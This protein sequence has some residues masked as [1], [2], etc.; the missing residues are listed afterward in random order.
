M[1]CSATLLRMTE[2]PPDIQARRTLEEHAIALGHER[3][4]LQAREAEIITQAIA[5]M[6]QE[7]IPAN[8]LARLLQ[9]DRTTLYRWRD[10]AHRLRETP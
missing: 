8:E 6:D 2:I 7:L 3:A 4:T 5:L 9:I 1:W 10:V